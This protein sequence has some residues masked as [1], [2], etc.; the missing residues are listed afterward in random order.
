MLKVQ[1]FPPHKG[2]NFSTL[3]EI[4]DNLH[5]SKALQ[6]EIKLKQEDKR[7]FLPLQKVREVKQAVATCH[8]HWYIVHV[9]T[10]N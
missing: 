2:L 3:V 6:N 1:D 5:F 9:Q 7:N 8:S 4:W 10:N